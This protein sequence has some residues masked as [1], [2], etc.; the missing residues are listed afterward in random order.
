MQFMHQQTTETVAWNL[1]PEPGIGLLLAAAQNARRPTS[2]IAL[3]S[4]HAESGIFAPRGRMPM[5]PIGPNVP[6][7]PPTCNQSLSQV[8]LPL[9]LNLHLSTAGP[10]LVMTGLLQ[11]YPV[12]V[13]RS[14][15]AETAREGLALVDVRRWMCL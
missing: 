3:H 11:T 7:M 2:C 10:S 12:H 8:R 13:M 9:C 4:L 5:P 14:S 6:P 1:A 15:T